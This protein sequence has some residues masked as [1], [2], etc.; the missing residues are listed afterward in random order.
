MTAPKLQPVEVNRFESFHAA[1]AAPARLRPPN[2]S[3]ECI[4]YW[5]SY[6]PKVAALGLEEV[7]LWRDIAER[8]IA[9]IA[10]L[11]FAPVL[12]VLAV[13]IRMDSPGPALFRQW[14]IGRGG[15]L[16]RFTKFRTYYED[17]RDRFPELYDYTYSQADMNLVHFK[18]PNDP[19]M[20]RIGNWLRQTTLD[21]LPNF[22]HVL[23]GEM[24]LVGPRPEIPDMFPH[25]RPQELRKFTV[26]PGV[27]GMSQISGRGNLSFRETVDYDL[28]Y[29]D[30]RSLAGDIAIVVRTI[31]SVVVRRG[32][33]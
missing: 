6:R 21:E 2:T 3:N 1:A 8:L 22:W 19:R 31:Q 33:F 30:G 27:T 29:V 9:L 28:E 15:K 26:R 24:S 7:P 10:L 25:Y 11:V 12:L 20:T 13:A 14:R 4:H 18:V 17:A 5:R 16:F 23:T 32:A